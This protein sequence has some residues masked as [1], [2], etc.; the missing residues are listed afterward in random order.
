MPNALKT[1]VRLFI[2]AILMSPI[3]CSPSTDSSAVDSP[4]A[5]SS[6]TDAGS[7]ETRPDQAA[8]NQA[9]SDRD[10][11]HW[12]ETDAAWHAE[13]IERLTAPEGWLSLVGF[14]WVEPGQHR[15]GSGPDRDIRLAVGPER[16]G[17][18][19]LDDDGLR[20][21]PEPGVAARLKDVPLDGEVLLATS[22][23]GQPDRVHF[24]DGQA[25]FEALVRGGRIALRV[26]DARAHTRTGFVG[27]ERFDPDPSW[28][29]EARFEPHPAGK[30][31]DIA[32]VLG[33]LEPMPNQGVLVFTRD[34]HDHRL[35]TVDEGDG[36]L[37][38]IF[39]DRTNSSDTYGAGRFLYADPP[40]DNGRSVLDFN[41]AYNP[42]CA[43]TAHSTCPLP[44]PENRMDV[45]VEAGERRY[46][47]PTS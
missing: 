6:V 23:D 14:H 24:D 28:R 47:G 43:F 13:R 1:I 5:D 29:F 15:I 18:I 22:A 26:R 35:E 42:P 37:F 8:S 40:D 30:T 39:A 36:R 32:N 33:Q 16:L 12:A 7:A 45:R 38:V 2:L 46:T 27:I 25:S 21:T 31:L 10:E 20:F 4:A 44:P 34:G 41:R 11:T 19:R 9:A 3:A 17:L